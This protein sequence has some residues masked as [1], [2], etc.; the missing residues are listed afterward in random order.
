MLTPHRIELTRN[1][2]ISPPALPAHAYLPV[3]AIY[4]RRSY[5]A[6]RAP[7]ADPLARDV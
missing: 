7:G 6:T 4:S 3:L 1:Q 5:E 2:A